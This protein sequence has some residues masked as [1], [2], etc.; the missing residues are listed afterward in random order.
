MEYET[1][2][3][4]AIATAQSRDIIRHCLL[5]FRY[6]TKTI[7]YV[8]VK[9]S[10]RDGDDS[11]TTILSS[12]GQSWSPLV[13][14]TSV[15]APLPAEGICRRRNPIQFWRRRNAFSTLINHATPCHLLLTGSHTGVSSWQF[16]NSIE[17][18]TLIT[19]L[20]KRVLLGHEIPI[21]QEATTGI[22]LA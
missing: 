17:P 14:T 2:C 1:R 15:H 3:V 12:F 22:F 13:S 9:T 4:V 8:D 18:I 11:L 7:C 21:I 5:R 6:W 20:L 16:F 10:L 19:P